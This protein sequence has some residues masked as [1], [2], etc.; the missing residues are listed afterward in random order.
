[1][2][3]L[4]LKDLMTQDPVTLNIDE[5]FCR[6]A[7]IFRARGI[8]GVLVGP[9]HEQERDI[10]FP[11]EEFALSTMGYSLHQPASSRAC[12]AHFR[13]MSFAMEE[14][15]YR[16]YRRIGYV[17]S[18]DFEDRVSS[19]WGAAYRFNQ[20]L[21]APADRVEPLVF[22][23]EATEKALKRWLEETQPDAVINAL[24]GV[25]ELLA[26]LKVRVPEDLGFVHLDL[27]AHLRAARVC[28]IDQL[29]ETVGAHALEIIASQLY[30]NASG[31]PEHPV[32][33]LVEGV[34]IE[35]TS[36]RPRPAGKARGR[37]AAPA[38]P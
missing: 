23:S 12:H 25:Y 28:G 22:K 32:T 11:W 5:S 34:W 29:S 37:A 33:Q 21:L 13:G 15:I 10:G 36:L 30:T 1:M 24:P 14:M 31:V 9:L 38:S 26:G 6:V 20:H 18:T 7:Q 16:G 19:L 3:N 4:R 35:G 17:T 2:K 8:R 27:P